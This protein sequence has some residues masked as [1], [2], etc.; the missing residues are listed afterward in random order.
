MPQRRCAGTGR[1]SEQ[2]HDRR[3]ALCWP[4]DRRTLVDHP[5]VTAVIWAGLG[6]METGKALVDVLMA[7]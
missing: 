5:N 4:N 7:P 3:R 6:G 2:Q 1:R